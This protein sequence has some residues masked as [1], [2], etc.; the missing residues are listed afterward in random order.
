M[1]VTELRK[2]IYKIFDE[3]QK[4]GKS[5]EVTRKGER[6]II[7]AKNKK[8]SKLQML[9]DFKPEKII[10]GDIGEKSDMSGWDESDW[11]ELDVLDEMGK[12][13]EKHAQDTSRH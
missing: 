5:I 10:V 9:M 2:N 12:S 1:T 11:R 4:T 7:E 3:V 6:F 8:K 13:S